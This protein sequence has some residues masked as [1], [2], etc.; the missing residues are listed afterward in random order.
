MIEKSAMSEVCTEKEV[1]VLICLYSARK[2]K[3]KR[4]KDSIC[5]SD[6]KGK[7]KMQTLSSILSCSFFMLCLFDAMGGR[8]IKENLQQD[9]R[10]R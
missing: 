2:E 10:D 1:M 6:D 4:K 7:R 3:G 8:G 9:E 5:K